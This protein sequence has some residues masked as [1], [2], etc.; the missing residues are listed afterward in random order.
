MQLQPSTAVQVTS[1]GLLV[2]Q[3]QPSGR[4]LLYAAAAIHSRAGHI[5]RPVEVFCLQLQPS[6]AVQVTSSGLL[7][8]QSQPSGRGL[9]CAAS[10]ID[11]RAGHIVRPVDATKP[12]VR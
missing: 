10:A 4:G 11:S 8:R 3:S 6:T 9:L 7:V 2:P 12:A 5:V 1:S